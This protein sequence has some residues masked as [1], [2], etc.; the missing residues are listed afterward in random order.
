LP[1]LTD[2]Q[3]DTFWRQGFIVIDDVI[4]VDAYIKPMIEEYQ[5]VIDRLADDLYAAGEITSKYEELPF[6]KRLIKIQQESNKVHARAFDFSLPFKGV[7]HNTPC[8]FGPAVFKML[9]NP[10]LLDVA[11]SIIGPEIYSN[12]VQHVRLKTPEHLT[13]VD[14]K[15]G[16][17]MLR[18]TE[19]HQDASVVVADADET[20]ML[21][22]WLPINEA[23]VE[24]GCLAVVP[25]NHEE[26]LLQHCITTERDKHLPEKFF[27]AD[28]A[29]PVPMKPGSALFMHRM[30]PH[31]SLSNNSDDV[32]W[33]MDLRYNPT[34]QPTGRPEFP[35]FVARSRRDPASELNDPT[36]WRKLWMD[37]RER[38]SAHPE[39][40]GTFSRWKENEEGCA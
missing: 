36:V 2:E 29:L 31:C 6:G 22:I 9:R 17:A 20:N 10:G 34:G 23:T 15:T 8:H 5:G 28:R 40:V 7:K 27:D 14:P 24:N 3:L 13:P 21:T 35:G 37:T 39:M 4:D 12:P 11:E 26:G 19:W 16:R 25:K 38:M 33:S 1:H 18:A 30:T 32:R